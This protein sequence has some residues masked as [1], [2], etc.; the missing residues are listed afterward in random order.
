MLPVILLAALSI[1]GLWLICQQAYARLNRQSLHLDRLESQYAGLIKEN[2][3]FAVEN[4]ALE[5]EVSRTI[6]LYELTRDMCVSLD[7][8][9]I[10]SIF[11]ARSRSFLAA[12]RC[13]F[14]KGQGAPAEEPGS[15]VVPVLLQNK[16]IGFLTCSGITEK[17]RE[18]FH[19]LAQQFLLAIRRAA[20]YERVQNLIVTDSLT[21]TMSRRYFLERYREE[22]DRS[23]EF[24]LD[25]S[26]LMIDIDRFKEC[27]DY[28]GHL[29][30]D[31][32]L[33]KVSEI[34]K[35]A[36]RQMDFIGRYGGEELSIVLVETDKQHAL[37][38]AERIRRAVEGHV[39]EIYDEKV[40]T[41][42]SVGVASFPGDAAEG[43]VLIEKADE[44]LY[45]AKKAGRNRVAG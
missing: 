36:V 3:R 17:N 9:Q 18:I 13:R 37:R 32:V 21:R 41:T 14:S 33:R 8:E 43:D 15:V 42:I 27:N 44:A 22:I 6:A 45:Q 30:G 29:V 2:D 40:R 11:E 34:L 20:L 1:I 28:Y 5:E 38:A 10:Y 31:A 26:F 16:A 35:D 19:V 4:R 12:G 24:R 39:F 7:Q 25:L 23:K